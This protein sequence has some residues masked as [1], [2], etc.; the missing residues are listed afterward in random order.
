M[1]EGQTL[2]DGKYLRLVK[3]GRW[4]YVSRKK[5]SGIVGIVAVTDAGKLVLV[6]QYRVPVG[7]NVIELPA[8]LAGDVAGQEAEPMEAAARRELLEETGYEAR[9]MIALTAGVASAG[10]CDEV[11]QLMRAT[12]LK[13]VAA[14]GGDASERITVHEVPLGEVEAWLAQRRKEGKLLDLKIYGALYFAGLSTG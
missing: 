11:I 14:G 13:K 9:E 5:V 8:G 12:G 6:E 10:L 4:E 2:Y 1:G 3:V 7:R